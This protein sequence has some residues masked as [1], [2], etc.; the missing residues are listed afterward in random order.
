MERKPRKLTPSEIEWVYGLKPED[1]TLKFL[2]ENFARFKN[3]EP[4]FHREDSFLMPPKKLRNDIDVATTIGRYIVNLF[5]FEKVKYPYVNE[6]LSKTKFSKI[7]AELTDW[8]I[9]DQISTEDYVDCINRVNWFGLSTTSFTSPSISIEGISCPP[10]T[11]ELRAQLFSQHSEQIAAGDAVA[12]T[13]IENALVAS[14][15][16][17][18]KDEDFA[19]IFVACGKKPSWGN[20]YKNMALMRGAVYNPETGGF[21]GCVGNLSD[22]TPLEEMPA[23]ANLL[24]AGAG[25]RALQTRL[26]GYISKQLTAAFQGIILDEPGS[27]CGVEEYNEVLLTAA[28]CGRFKL[29][30]I[31]EKNGLVLLDRKTMAKYVGKTVLMRSPMY[32]K[33]WKFCSKCYG[34]LPYR[35]G[36]KNIGLT[37]NMIGEILK[38]IAMKSFHDSTMKTSKFDL[39]SAITQL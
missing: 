4:R 8:L 18:L 11:E 33:T 10:K 17:E 31:K 9:E 12:I 30:Y 6:G 14:A 28:N 23:G 22:G 13:K 25:G 32:C 15:K 29:R 5:A 2:R 26:G 37:Y 21:D 38:G 16:E 20:Q 24:L 27:D 34:E 39:A 19:S 1:I 3:R 7:N 35:I 36:I